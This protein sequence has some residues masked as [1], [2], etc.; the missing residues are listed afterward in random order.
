MKLINQVISFL[1]PK[2][3]DEFRHEFDSSLLYQNLRRFRL[4]SWAL[5]A[6][7]TAYSIIDYYTLSTLNTPES[8]A[9]F[10]GLTVFRVVA[11]SLTIGF[12]LLLGMP[13]PLENLQPRHE[14][15]GLIYAYVLHIFIV[16][17]TAYAYDYRGSIS[18]FI[19]I[20][21]ASTCFLRFYP[22]PNLFLL[23]VTF[24]MLALALPLMGNEFPAYS[25]DLA[26]SFVMVFLSFFVSRI[27]FLNRI[28]ELLNTKLIEK[29]N[30]ELGKARQVA[31]EA[32][33]A[34]SEFL[35]TM[36]HEIRTPMNV[37]LGM[38]EVALE[39]EL[40]D[41]VRDYLQR[42]M[43]SSNQLLSIISDVLDYSK[44]EF[45][46]MGLSEEEFNLGEV[47]KTL[48]SQ[49]EI[50]AAA[51]GI[52]L[53]TDFDAGL[54]STVQGDLLRIRQILLNL[55]SNAIKFTEVGT[56]TFK[57]KVEEYCSSE[58]A[59]FRFIV[60]D[61]GIGIEAGQ[62]QTVFNSFEQADN[63]VTRRF[64]GTGLGLAISKRLADL[65]DGELTLESEPGRGAT[66]TLAVPLKVVGRA[67]YAP[68][69]EPAYR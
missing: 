9:L 20:I 42:S 32:S 33:R 16:L 51:K 29:Q 48:V 21:V 3:P 62:Q 67:L 69:A 40:S 45:G 24:T 56:V 50:G 37:V 54:P 27:I 47:L 58:K 63:S 36:S 26:T 53:L 14:K 59:V 4:M 6:A 28:K 2:I 18:G 61:T 10:R 13:F 25:Y 55:L 11:A 19:S 49:V 23:A 68:P 1:F 64:G 41:E 30:L 5:L 15:L 46:K 66:F 65:M 44:I 8:W 60:E 17:I 7:L 43:N 31:E 57:V 35:A 34:K 38:T 12:L 52:M 22:L 39:C